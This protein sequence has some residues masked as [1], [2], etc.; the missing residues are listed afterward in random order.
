MK[1][2]S[3]DIYRLTKQFEKSKFAVALAFRS[4]EKIEV[5][6]HRDDKLMI[7]DI[8]MAAR[9]AHCL[10]SYVEQQDPS[11]FATEA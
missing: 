10:M 8:E 7:S 11:F 3:K 6:F 9:A 1:F 2:D 4:E 5:S